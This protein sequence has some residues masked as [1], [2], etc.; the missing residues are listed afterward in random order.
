MKF[1]HNSCSSNLEEQG[2]NAWLPE[3]HDIGTRNI[4]VYDVSDPIFTK[5]APVAASPKLALALREMFF[6]KIKDETKLGKSQ[7]MIQ[8]SIGDQITALLEQLADV[9][10]DSTEKANLLKA[11]KH[12]RGFQG[13]SI[14]VDQFEGRAGETAKGYFGE[15]ASC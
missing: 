9:T 5:Q 13:R 15:I 3:S 6:T 11:K 7:P 4:R 12:L 8:I 10:K 1:D 2:P 14:R